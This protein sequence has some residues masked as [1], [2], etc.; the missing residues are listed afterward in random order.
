[1]GVASDATG[2]LRTAFLILTVPK[3]LGGVCMLLS[4]WTFEGDARKVLDEARG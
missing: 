1:M 3:L 2:S 4:R